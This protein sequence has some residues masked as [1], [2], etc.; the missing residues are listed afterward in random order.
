MDQSNGWAENKKLI[1]EKFDHL[2]ELLKELKKAFES[3]DVIVR[4]K[5]EAHSVEIA[6][7]KT[8]GMLTWGLL[9]ALLLATITQHLVASG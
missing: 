8:R 6:K 3:H 2:E 1:F 7:L 9:T 4:A 5:L